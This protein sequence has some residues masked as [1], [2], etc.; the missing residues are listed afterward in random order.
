MADTDESIDWAIE[1]MELGHESPT[2]YM[3][4]SVNKPSNYFEIINYVIETVKELGLEIKNGNDAILS[5]CSY[6]LIQITKEKQVRTNLSA[7]YQ[8]CQRREYKD[9]VFDFYLLNW[10][11]DDLNHEENVN[12]HYW[13]GASK[14]NIEQIVVKEAKRWIEKY[15]KHFEQKCRTK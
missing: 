13:E 11:W 6:F 1:M 5:Y 9:L 3:L 10:A 14:A 7:L 12:N 8:F 4:A 2:L 15:K